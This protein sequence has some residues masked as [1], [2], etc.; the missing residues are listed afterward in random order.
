MNKEKPQTSQMWFLA[1]HIKY[2]IICV[3]TQQRHMPYSPQTTASH[4]SCDLLNILLSFWQ[5]SWSMECMYAHMHAYVWRHLHMHV[6]AENEV[7]VTHF[8]FGFWKSNIL[9]DSANEIVKQL[10]QENPLVISSGTNDLDNSSKTFQN[11]RNYLVNL[12]HTNVLLLSIPF[13]FDLTNY[14]T[15]NSK[16]TVLN[17]KL[18][19]LTRTLPYTRFL[20]S[21]NNWK[22]FT[23]HGLHRNKLGKQLVTAQIAQHILI[24]LHH[25]T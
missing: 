23:N 7:R 3:W 17:K 11:L 16:I 25:R 1:V 5:T 6:H 15:M 12:N 19:K 14:D 21:D 9:K 10:S 8:Y 24:T 18:Q 22:L 20:D 4:Q 2:H 13:R